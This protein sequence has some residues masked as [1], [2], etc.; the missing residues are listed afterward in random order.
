VTCNYERLAERNSKT[1]GVKTDRWAGFHWTAINLPHTCL[2]S[3]RLQWGRTRWHQT[4]DQ[5]SRQT[6]GAQ[7]TVRQVARAT[8]LGKVVTGFWVRNLVR[9]TKLAL[10]ILGWPLH[11]W[12]ICARVV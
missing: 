4:L 2:V 1:H 10:G 9:V 12:K 3:S 7:E 8:E 6:P 11:L 5:L